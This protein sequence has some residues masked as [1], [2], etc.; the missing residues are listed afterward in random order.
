LYTKQVFYAADLGSGVPSETKFRVCFVHPLAIVH[1]L[2]QRL[3]CI[4]DD[5]L[6]GGGRCVD[7][8][9]QLLLYCAGRSLNDL[10]GGDLIGNMVG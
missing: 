6:N 8:I 1:Y 9:F 2:H 7:R 3:A 10:S 4:I 5:K